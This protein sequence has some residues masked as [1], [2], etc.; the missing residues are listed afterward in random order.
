VKHVCMETL[1]SPTVLRTINGR[2]TLS[3]GMLSGRYRLKLPSVTLYR[4]AL[5]EG[6]LLHGNRQQVGRCFLLGQR[7]VILAGH[8]PE[9][10]VEREQ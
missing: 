6:L 2:R 5:L 8:D 1:D 9:Y 4:I 10:S 3:S 7:G